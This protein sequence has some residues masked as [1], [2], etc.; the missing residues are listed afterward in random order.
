MLLNLVKV[1]D[2]EIKQLKRQLGVTENV[3]DSPARNNTS[4][5][6]KSIHGSGGSRHDGMKALNFEGQGRLED[7][8]AQINQETLE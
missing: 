8:L 6:R 5:L 3:T 2:E 7:Q 4:P 1:K